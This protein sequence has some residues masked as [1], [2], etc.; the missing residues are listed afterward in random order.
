LAVLVR[1]EGG[2]TNPLQ[3]IRVVAALCVLPWLA[4]LVLRRSRT[5]TLHVDRHSVVLEQRRRRVVVPLEAVAAVEPW[6]LPLPSAGFVLRLRSGRRW[7]DGI[8]MN[9]PSA[10][11]DALVDAGASAELRAAARRPAMVYAQARRT[12]RPDSWY[13]P[14]LDFP[15]FA[16][17]PTI[18]LFRVHQIIAYG[19]AIGEYYQYGLGAYLAGFA[20]YWATLTIYLMVYA[21]ALRLPVEVLSFGVA[22][23]A[24]RYA[25]GG[26]RALE[27]A[28]GILYYVGV[29]AALVLRF[30]PW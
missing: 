8:A 7:S 10:A 29:P 30:L 16:L 24:P 26:R 21:A 19:G 14:L 5:G 9:D 15:V 18:P 23:L 27:R 25:T 6:R 17:V 11:I 22:T 13:R 28:A 3:L 12:D 20:V 1:P 4:G 2:P